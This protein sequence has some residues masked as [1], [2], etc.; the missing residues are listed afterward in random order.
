MT[1]A[2]KRLIITAGALIAAGAV[3]L[4]A[5][6]LLGGKDAKKLS[7]VKYHTETHIIT[8]DFSDISA[9]IGGCDMSI[10]PSQDGKCTVV[11]R[12]EENYACAVGV[13]DGFLS[14][15][16]GENDGAWYSRV[17][18]FSGEPGE[19]ITVYL[20]AGE[21][22][23]LSINGKSGSVSVQ[24]GAE[25][26]RAEISL[27]SGDTDFCAGVSGELLLYASSGDISAGSV[28]PASLGAE[29]SSGSIELADLSVRGEISLKSTSGDIDLDRSDCITLTCTATSGSVELDGVR[30][31]KSIDVITQSGDV[32][33]EG[34]DARSIGIK[35][36]SGSVS[37]YLL[38]D[39]FF[40]VTTSSGSV[41][42]P[43][44]RAAETCRIETAS[45]DVC[46]KASGD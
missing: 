20:P 11:C 17:N 26:E 13:K 30:A 29:T 8:D 15:T 41:S 22:G 25:F 3:L 6:L 38:S 1:S 24:P 21:Y 40:D 43:Q 18:V 14:I 9:F 12:M 28:S 36:T 19:R 35:T 2:T 39:K 16:R 7:T 23:T 37:G 32:E 5:A 44:S 27:N 42:V 10:E 33:L 34:S 45:G 46:F 4:G 31:S